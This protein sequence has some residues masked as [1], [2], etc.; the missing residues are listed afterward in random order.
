MIRQRAILFFFLIFGVSFISQYNT[1]NAAT[2]KEISAIKSRVISAYKTFQ[3]EVDVSAYNL[4][5]SNDKNKTTQMMTEIMTQ[6]PGLFY[7]GLTY[8]KVINPDTG[9]V[10]RIILSYDKEYLS[11]DGSVNV[12]KIKKAQKKIDNEVK[13]ALKSVNSKMSKL[14]KALVLHDYLIQNTAYYNGASLTS[15]TTEAGLFLDKKANCQGYALSYAILM[16]RIGVP[17]KFVSSESMEHIWNMIKIGGKWYHVDVTWDDPVE[18]YGKMD[19]YG[20]VRHDYF[21]CSTKKMKKEGYKGFS[22]SS[23]TSTK[24]DNMWWRSIS[25]TIHY[26]NGKWIYINQ[27]GIASKNKLTSSV[28]AKVLRM[29]SGKAMI[30]LNSNLYYLITQNSVYLYNYK[31]NSLK[32]VWSPKKRYGSSYYLTQIKYKSGRIYYR[33]LSGVNYKNGSFKVN[34]TNGLAG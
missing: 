24:Y 1:V 18:L 22:A 9:H 34:K 28:S 12:T 4:N 14:E 10:K 5:H 8:Q 2:K 21:L 15:R 33:V 23:A 17:V 16:Q 29:L 30:R 19:Q 32:R 31:K 7:S 20:L 11:G 13:A 6:T 26:R 27:K 25:S 3:K